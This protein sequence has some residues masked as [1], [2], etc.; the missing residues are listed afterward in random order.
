MNSCGICGKKYGQDHV[1]GETNLF[2]FDKFESISST[3]DTP[4]LDRAIEAGKAG[5][6]HNELI[7]DALIEIRNLIGKLK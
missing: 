4:A 2:Q 6:L 1:C 7:V 5:T 3:P